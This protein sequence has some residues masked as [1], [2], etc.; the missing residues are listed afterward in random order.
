MPACT[1]YMS[2]IAD[3]VQNVSSDGELLKEI[4]EF[5]QT[6]AEGM[7]S[8]RVLGS[9]FLGRVGDMKFGKGI[10]CLHVQTAIL[11]AQ[12]ASPAHRVVDNMCQLISPSSVQSLTSKKVLASTL[13][14]EQMMVDARK[15][16]M[17]FKDAL[18]RDEFITM[19]GKLDIRL[20]A[21]LLKLGQLLCR[22]GPAT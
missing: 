8:K 7:S 12:L 4:T 2:V 22:P 21:H 19:L 6:R 13:A 20:V 11:K 14:I 1:P 5:Q 16:A 10:K 9:I 18:K 17:P 3:Y 15:L